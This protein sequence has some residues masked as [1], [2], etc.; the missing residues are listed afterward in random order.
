MSDRALGHYEAIVRA[1]PKF[2]EVVLE[3]EYFDTNGQEIGSYGEAM[4]GFACTWK[5]VA[6][7]IRVGLRKHGLDVDPVHHVSPM[8]DLS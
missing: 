7:A 6:T 3:V 5:D 4:I 2:P 8:V 1:G